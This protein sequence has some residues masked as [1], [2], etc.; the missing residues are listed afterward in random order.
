[1]RTQPQYE[2][3]GTEH[4]HDG[5]N[6]EHR[7]RA[8]TSDGGRERAFDRCAEAVSFDFLVRVG[9]H[10]RH[11]IEDFT[12]HGGGIGDTVLRIPRERAHAAAIENDRQ[13][14]D[15]QQHDDD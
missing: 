6:R 14:R 3:D 7:A 5:Q 2:H 13:Y 10:G 11:G 4:Q 9:L 12:R 15:E 8:N 1:M